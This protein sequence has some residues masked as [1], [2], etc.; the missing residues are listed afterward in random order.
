MISTNKKNAQ[1][2]TN[3]PT[4]TQPRDVAALFILTIVPP[5]FGRTL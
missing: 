5:M 2:N 4:R 1:Q 3:H